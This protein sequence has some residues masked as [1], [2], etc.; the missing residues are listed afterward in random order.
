VV[1]PGRFHLFLC[2]VVKHMFHILC[3]KQ[4]L[5]QHV[6][7]VRGMAHLF[8]CIALQILI[9]D[10]TIV[11]R[12]GV[13]ATAGWFPSVP[14]VLVMAVRAIVATSIAAASTIKAI[15]KAP[16]VMTTIVQVCTIHMGKVALNEAGR[17][18]KQIRRIAITL[19][20]TSMWKNVPDP[21]LAILVN[22]LSQ[23]D[24]AE[25]GRKIPVII[26][27][28]GVHVRLDM[29]LEN[30]DDVHVLCM[31]DRPKECAALFGIVMEQAKLGLKTEV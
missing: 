21:R 6:T 13:A 22:A 24:K 28:H 30:C 9:I 18:V 10:E 7:C 4:S 8:A 5:C 12:M 20:V 17:M 1:E 3:E 16:L 25:M 2:D 29:C 31:L 19:Y 26:F 15:S 23:A 11:I 14:G 27:V